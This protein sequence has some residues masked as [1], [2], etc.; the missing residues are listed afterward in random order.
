MS[1]H[2]NEHGLIGVVK[3]LIEHITG[4]GYRTLTEILTTVKRMDERE[5]IFMATVKEQL[6]SVSA[7]LDAAGT[8]LDNIAAD[9]AAQTKLITDLQAQIAAG[10]V[11]TAEQLQP[12][13]DKSAAIAAKASAAADSIPD[14]PPTV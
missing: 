7:S 10:A 8:A 3:M 5:V 1:E 14:T 12:L 11:I 9:E 13:V 6:D 4:H 2:D